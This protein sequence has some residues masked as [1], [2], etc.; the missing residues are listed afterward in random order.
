MSMK[1]FNVTDLQL[2]SVD[3]MSQDQIRG[4]AFQIVKD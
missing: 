4:Y 2:G 3:I 1:K